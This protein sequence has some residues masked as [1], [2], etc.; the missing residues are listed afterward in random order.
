M[1]WGT[2][3]HLVI[4]KGVLDKGYDLM[5]V[6]EDIVTLISHGI[7]TPVPSNAIKV[8]VELKFLK[9]DDKT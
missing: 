9:E 7:K 4:R 6:A 5:A 3:E 1:I 2:I 8:D